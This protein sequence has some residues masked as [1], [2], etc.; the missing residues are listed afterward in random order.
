MEEGPVFCQFP[1]E[2]SQSAW[3]ELS[4]LAAA[5]AKETLAAE[6]E[7]LHRVDLHTN[8]GLPPLVRRCLR[9]IPTEGPTQC[10]PRIMRFDFHWTR[11]GWQISEA[12]TDVAGG[13]IESSGATR[14]MA[15]ERQES[16]LPGDPAG[17]L[18]DAVLRVVGRGALVGL[19]H[20]T[21][22]SE[23]RQVMLYLARRLEEAGLIT[24]LFSPEQLRWK[25]GQAI[26]DCDWHKGPVDLLI[27]FFPTEWL[28]RLP[29]KTA[30]AGFFAGGR[31]RVSNPAY[32]VLTQ[33]KRFPLVWDK[34]ATRL[35]TWRSLLPQTF[36]PREVQVTL[37]GDWVLKPALG[38]EGHN[39][40]IHGVNEPEDW[41]RVHNT[42]KKDPEAWAAQRRFEIL[43]LITSDGPM[44]PCVGVY[45]IDG[46]VAGAYGRVASRPLIDDRS[47]EV[48]VLVK[49]ST[50]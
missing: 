2:L 32:A 45:V 19:M 41:E 13:F 3:S 50:E 48:A 11:D 34:L 37:D 40:A 47:R 5:L 17:I 18:S 20:L 30:W 24:C 15:M 23:D 7:L 29:S 16:R 12:N 9:C 42:A 43:P 46:C 28:P 35:A 4:S 10:G 8:L 1:L 21:I 49:H 31:T 33:S 14:L 38:H 39:V 22:Y 26:V 6:M 36:S 27:R 25:S 44:Y